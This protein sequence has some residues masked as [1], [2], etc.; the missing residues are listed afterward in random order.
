MLKLKYKTQ[1]PLLQPVSKNFQ[2]ENLAIKWDHGIGPR[3][4][5]IMIFTPGFFALGDEFDLKTETKEKSTD[6]KKN[7]ADGL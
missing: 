1:L 3:D 6:E 4:F 2:R 5:W 7:E